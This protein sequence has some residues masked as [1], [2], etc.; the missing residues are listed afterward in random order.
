MSSECILVSTCLLAGLRGTGLPQP[1]IAT[2]VGF[3]KLKTDHHQNVCRGSSAPWDKVHDLKSW[4]MRLSASALPQQAG[5]MCPAW[6]M[7]SPPSSS[8]QRHLCTPGL[9]PCTCLLRRKTT[10]RAANDL[11][12][13]RAQSNSREV[14]RGAQGGPAPGMGEATASPEPLSL[15]RNRTNPLEA[16]PE[17]YMCACHSP[18]L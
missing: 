1:G 3:L 6:N 9:A 11:W 13:P 2:Q 17:T 18:Q 7:L 4:K 8:V 10:I 15:V 5:H 12:D 14:E 16:S